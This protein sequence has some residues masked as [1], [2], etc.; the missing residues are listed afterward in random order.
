MA[1]LALVLT[2]CGGNSSS[3][4][5]SNTGSEAD[6]EAVLDVAYTLAMPLDPH[7]PTSDVA[8]FTYT[9]LVYD[10]LVQVK[11][12]LKVEP[13][14]AD[15]WEFAADGM[16][17]DFT[18]HEGVTFSDGAVLDAEAVKKSLDRAI[19]DKQSTVAY[20]FSMVKQIDVVDASTVRIVTNRKAADLP[21]V[22]AGTAGSIIS[23]NALSNAD[24]DVK[25]VGSGP[26]AVTKINLGQSVNYER[27]SDY[28]GPEKG[29][30]KNINITSMPDENARLNA[31]RSGQ[32][33]LIPVAL[34]NADAGES[35]G[36]GFDM[37]TYPSG[38]TW[39]LFLNTTTEAMSN[40]KV[41]QALNYAIDREAISKSLLSGKC[42]P[43]AQQLAKGADGFLENPPQK[44]TYDPEKA[45]K[46]L[47]EAGYPEGVKAELL[48]S[49]GLAAHE[50]LG[51]ALQAQLGEI[52]VDL[53]IVKKDPA[54]A[55]ALY[56]SE[57]FETY[58]QTRLAAAT[59]ALNLA[60]NF[61]P[62]RFPGPIPKEFTDALAIANDPNL[63]ASEVTAALETASAVSNE[64][65]FDLFICS[66]PTLIAHNDE[67]KGADK[68]GSAYYTGTLDLRAVSVLK[69]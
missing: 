23:P 19:F 25:P 36:S 21:A 40:V 52:G 43:G 3:D 62:P 14:L 68:M 2:A 67:V 32:V 9:S 29:L 69:K 31:L 5:S 13:M 50:A 64:Q 12:G 18:L 7:R 55:P 30:A 26:Y 53:T 1:S 42:E 37:F 11:P 22:L 54:Q 45:K 17:V 27:R 49:Q 20:R 57:G 61:S 10:R 38:A 35:L 28:W 58:I 41:R 34:T 51:T 16:S 24:L 8:Q 46:L 6:T 63:G 59:S 47:E 44:Y 66:Y 48:F 56:A 39:A 4:N 33:D 65:A 15:S 60:G